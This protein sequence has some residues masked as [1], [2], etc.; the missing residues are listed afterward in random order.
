MSE[1]LHEMQ[2]PTSAYD[3]YIHAKKITLSDI[4]AHM[5]GPVISVVLHI[6]LFALLGTMIVYEPPQKKDEITVEVKN[7]EIKPLDKKPEPPTPPEEV[8]DD[9]VPVE[10]DRPTISNEVVATEVSNVSVDNMADSAL[11]MPDALSIKLN[12]SALKLPGVM[13]ARTATGRKTAMKKYAK[14]NVTKIDN[15]VTRALKWLAQVQNEDGSW[16][17]NKGQ[18]AAMTSMAILTFLAHGDTPQDSPEH[19]EVVLK[20]LRKL[21]E[22]VDTIPPNGKCIQL[23]GNG[24]A[25]AMVAYAVSEGYAMTK[26][27]MLERAMNRITQTIVDGQNN[28]GSYNYG[29]N[30]APLKADPATGKV[31]EGGNIGDPRCDLSVAG[32]NYQALKA[33]FAAGCTVPGLEEAIDKGI[34]A[35]E[36]IHNGKN[37]TFCYGASRG[38]GGGTFTMTSVGTLCLHLM[39]AGNKSAAKDGVKWLMAMKN[40]GKEGTELTMDWKNLPGGW[41]LYGWYYMTQALFQGTN[42]T[43]NAWKKWDS[44][45]SS[46]LTKE[47][48]RE[49]FWLSPIDK[50][51]KA[52]GGHAESGKPGPVDPKTGKPTAALFT[53]LNSKI[54]TT[55]MCT[56]M[57]EVYYRHLP[58][59]KVSGHAEA[60]TTTAKETKEDD[61]T[62]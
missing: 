2:Q 22:Y 34:E 3:S 44:S 59:F 28:L 48:D 7:V 23:S 33:A 35:I 41:A 38:Q 46:T 25:H 42:G 39:G 14:G 4:Y 56:L 15:A 55:T 20:G 6:I 24:Y 51:G 5:T 27:P 26:T 19:G 43:G 58:S 29:F 13:A 49:G 16:G 36:K 11:V 21:V 61:L 52:V 40:G 18:E 9:V 32:W 62:L 53:E 60:S 1:Q 8:V 30:N 45:F 54:W 37:G 17:D 31:A 57:L 10:V 12:N 47:Q 50:Y